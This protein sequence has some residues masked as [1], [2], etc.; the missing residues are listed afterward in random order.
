MQKDINSFCESVG[1]PP[2]RFRTI[3]IHPTKKCNLTCLHCYS[4]S[5]PGYHDVL[6]L[7]NLKS[8]LA[9]AFDNG[10]N[11]ISV[12]GGEPFLY[13]DLEELL[14]F[15]RS[16]GYQNT[17]ASNGMLL[18]SE[19]A[20]RILD[21]VDLIAISVDG[22]QPLHDKIRNQAGAFDKM[23]Q[24]LEVL[25]DLDKPFGIIHTLTPESWTSLIWLGE[26]AAS[27]GA[28]LLQ[29]HPLEM[30]GRAL[31]TLTSEAIDDDLAHKMFI[32]GHY[33][34]SKYSDQLVVQLDML[35]RD[36]LLAHPQIVSGFERSCGQSGKLADLLDT[37]VIEESGT[38]LPVSYGFNPRYS[39]GNISNFSMSAF[40]DFERQSI[41]DIKDIF[42]NTLSRIAE[43][44][45]RDIV[46]W[47]E[48]LIE[49]SHRSMEVGIEI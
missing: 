48:L 38:I 30:Y 1:Q 20:K 43:Y 33:L 27:N 12:S 47:N 35:H 22:P 39:I 16:I 31:D 19:R 18:R 3:Q 8:F 24:G 5:A 25:K 15:S 17:L 4:S 7:A 42:K 37:I 28:K 6:D 14:Q 11:N 45:T 46:N 44:G 36:Y 41:P 10:F 21:F 13:K 29:L 40:E 34:V 32:L 49:E 9:Y 23:C 2:D 26:F